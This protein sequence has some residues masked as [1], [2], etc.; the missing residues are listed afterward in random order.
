MA[1]IQVTKVDATSF[2]V[3]VRDG[4]ETKHTVTVSEQVYQSLTGGAVE[5]EKLVEASFRFLLQRESNT[6]IL[7]RF[8]LPLIGS[9]FPEFE[10]EI[11]KQ[12][13]T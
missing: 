10:R 1:D 13:G 8:D 3:T 6:M 2:D 11:R 5:P 12:L 7:S 9:Y 4:S